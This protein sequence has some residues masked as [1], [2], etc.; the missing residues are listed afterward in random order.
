MEHKASPQASSLKRW[1][2]SGKACTLWDNL[3]RDPELWSRDGNC[4]V[5]LYAR[6]DSRRGPSFK[7]NL[8]V[9]L[10]A[11]F[12]PL[13]AKYAVRDVPGLSG[14]DAE[15][16]FLDDLM[17]DANPNDK[18]ELYIPA[19]STA[20][21]AEAALHHLTIR[22]IFAWV[23][24]ISVVGEHLGVALISLLNSL[25]EFRCPDEDNMDSILGYMDEE[26]YLDMPNQPYHAMAML[27]FAEHFQLKDLYTDALCHCV[28]MYDQ[29]NT[30]P[31]YQVITSTTRKLIRQTKGEMD[32]KLRN[33]G[34]ML[35]SFLESDLQ[36]AQ[37]RLSPGERAHLKYFR[38]FLTA[39]F[40]KRLGR[41]PPASIDPPALVFEPKVYKLMYEDMNALYLHLADIEF[42]TRTLPT[43]AQLQTG[44]SIL[45]II[46]GFDQR[47][48]YP[49]LNHPLPLIPEIVAKTNSRRISWLTKSDKLKP[50]QRLVSHAAM[51]KA[52]NKQ[53]AILGN[54]LVLAYRKFEEDAVFFPTKVDRGEKLSH[55]DT[56]KTRW[57]LI[58]CVY[59]VV[60]S[61][62]LPPAGCA[63]ITSDL[64]YN[65]AMD[66]TNL[67]LPWAEGQSPAPAPSPKTSPTI[68]GPHPT[69][70]AST[71][72][73]SLAD[74]SYYTKPITKE[75]IP[76]TTPSL[77]SRTPSKLVEPVFYT[78]PSVLLRARSLHRGVRPSCHTF[79]PIDRFSVE[80]LK[81]PPL[82][83]SV[84]SASTATSSTPSSPENTYKVS[85]STTIAPM[86][87]ML[88]PRS[89]S[90]SSCGIIYGEDD[91]DFTTLLH[92]LP[93]RPA[94]PITR[95]KPQLPTAQ[96]QVHGQQQHQMMQLKQ[97]IY[98]I[99]SMRTVS[100]SVYSDDVASVVSVPPPPLPK[101]SS[102]RKLPGLHPLPL[103][104]RKVQGSVGLSGNSS[105]GNTAAEQI[106]PQ[107]KM[108]GS[109]VE[110]GYGQGNEAI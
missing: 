38:T 85:S 11:K 66:M 58:Y 84:R 86:H 50:D 87:P 70:S 55:A 37:I 31:E 105:S 95:T 33:A 100:S 10:A 69:P 27:H 15:E 44:S 72:L 96:T 107:M 24:R 81:P 88:S 103:R 30:I 16:A 108:P 41:Y 7:V 25:S 106:E 3:K 29:L 45:Q 17:G 97:S 89:S 51:V 78:P 102:K 53:K 80:S 101:K 23:F 56:R 20:T 32:T 63:G 71:S 47:N 18:V 93:L 48:R 5:H 109:W 19:P 22:N 14:Y 90:S 92:P 110:T 26:G 98:S 1:D 54:K 40:T 75:D 2:G 8:D 12:H 76:K 83:L 73:Q 74:S 21:K 9:L 49:A 60:R 82:S 46:H 65:I 104:I 39:F 94:P 77:A 91:I 6:G 43:M 13:V 64:K 68:A 42:T 36:E 4:L 62:A 52:T 59:Q 79:G 34:Q 57:S 35:R 28:G 67:V 61:C 99:H